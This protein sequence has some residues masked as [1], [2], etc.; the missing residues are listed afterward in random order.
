MCLPDYTLIVLYITTMVCHIV[1]PDLIILRFISGL[2]TIQLYCVSSEARPVATIQ[3]YR[4]NIP[5]GSPEIASK[6]IVIPLQSL[7]NSVYTCVG[8]NKAGNMMHTVQK[9][10]RIIPGDK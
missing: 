4:D 1:P 10:L 2:K 5:L 8:K 7:L 6:S 3:W 9:T